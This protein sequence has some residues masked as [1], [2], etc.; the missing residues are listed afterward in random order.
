MPHFSI[1]THGHT[2][3]VTSP[4]ANLTDVVAFNVKDAQTAKGK[5]DSHGSGV[6][7]HVSSRVLKGINDA[8]AMD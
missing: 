7:E 2:R 4:A 1:S 8:S 3:D 6:F 5:R